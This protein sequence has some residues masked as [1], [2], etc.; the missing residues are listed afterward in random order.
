MQGGGYTRE[1][2]VGFDYDAVDERLGHVETKR[3]DYREA[4]KEMLQLLN[5]ALSHVIMSKRPA[6]AAWQVAFGLGLPCCEGMSM[7]SVAAELRVERATL[8]K[9]AVNF[10]KAYNLPPSEY[11]RSEPARKAYRARR[12]RQ[13][14]QPN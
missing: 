2:S 3:N 4:G 9:G 14:V 13:L 10:C 8:S 6:T 5:S 11:M 7:D 1:Q 12:E